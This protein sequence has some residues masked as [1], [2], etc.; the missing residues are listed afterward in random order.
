MLDDPSGAPLSTGLF[1]HTDPPKRDTGREKIGIIIPTAVNPIFPD[2][3]DKLKRAAGAVGLYSFVCNS[4]NYLQ[5]E[6]DCISALN[7][8]NVS[9]IIAMPVC[10]ESHELYLE[11]N[12][13][14]VFYGCRSP[15]ES[16]G[17]L[18]MDDI[19]AGRIAAQRLLING[20]REFAFLSY[21]PDSYAAADRLNGFSSVVQEEGSKLVIVNVKSY[22]LED[23]YSAMRSLLESASLPT[24]IA[25]A[26]DFIA[27]GAWQA[28]R[29][30]KLPVGDG[31]ALLGFG[32]TPFAALPKH[33]LSSVG[34]VGE[35]QAEEAVS[36]LRAMESGICGMRSR[37]LLT[38]QLICRSTFSDRTSASSPLTIKD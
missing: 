18:A 27:I 22:R 30:R 19:L 15:E 6:A 9:G 37:Q 33:G 23:S 10:N 2:I 1:Y 3:A 34:P 8:A 29:E 28:L 32:N 38:P 14:V 16:V 26:D 20:H 35:N 36:L 7:Y 21:P 12:S 5:H 11:S 17:Y 24:A 13:P 31:I 4:Q 25:A